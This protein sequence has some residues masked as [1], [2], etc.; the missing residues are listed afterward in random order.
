[1]L[2]L[3]TGEVAPPELNRSCVQQLSGDADVHPRWAIFFFHS[4]SSNLRDREVRPLQA[5]G[6]DLWKIKGVIGMCPAGIPVRHIQV[7]CSV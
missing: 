2:H 6:F 3:H 5:F 4:D 1:M 7:A